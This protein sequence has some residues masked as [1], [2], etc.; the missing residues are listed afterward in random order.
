MTSKEKISAILA[1]D[2]SVGMGISEHFWPET[3]DKWVKEG[4]LEEGEN[5]EFHFD[6]DIIR[7]WC[8]GDMTADP[9]NPE[10]IIEETEETKLFK[11]GN[12]ATLKLW[13]NKSGVPEHVDFDIKDYAAWTEK[14]KPVALDESLYDVR[15]K[16]VVGP[17][18]EK[19]AMAAEKDKFFCWAGVSVFEIMHPVCGHEYMLMGMALEP[20]WIKE[21]GEV[22][23]D[24][25]IKLAKKL[26][27]EEG[28]PDGMWFYEDMGF[29][30]KPFMS[31]AM[32]MEL[33][34]PYQKKLFSFAHS[35][36]KQV[37]VHSCGYVEALIPGLIDAGMNCLQAMEVKAGMDVKKIAKDY[38]GKIALCGGLDIRVLETNDKS[39]V[40]AY[41]EDTLP[42]V[43]DNVPY[44]LHT[45]H[46]IPQSVEYDTYRYFI[47]TAFEIEAKRG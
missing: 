4:H 1:G 23:S 8:S 30:F 12:G 32:Y 5:P 17:Y 25:V 16:D 46:S 33:V 15:L 21:M 2:G 40:K 9:H 38:S 39:Q 41:L 44:I 18:R 28:E 6:F 27:A 35:L 7:N 3:V 10:T 24:L 31:P 34:Q 13:K 26:F 29:K 20:D 37:M 11:N 19:K 43:L 45:D 47:D 14:I 36:D 22:Y 42:T